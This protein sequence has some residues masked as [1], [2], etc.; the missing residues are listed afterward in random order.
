M[1]IFLLGFLVV[2]LTH[3]SQAGQSD[4]G[5]ND[6]NLGGQEKETNKSQLDML[7]T[8]V[9]QLQEESAHL[10]IQTKEQELK[11][12]EQQL[13]LQDQQLQLQELTKINRARKSTIDDLDEHVKRL[14]HAE[15][16][17]LIAGLS[18]CEV[19]SHYAN[20]G[21]TKGEEYFDVTKKFTFG[22]SF[23]QTPKV[24][25]AIHGFYRKSGDHGYWSRAV[26]ITTTKFEL[27]MY[28]NG[29]YAVGAIWIACA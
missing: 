9:Q 17:P 27:N 14:I 26:S 29:H 28:G 3:F 1:N 12:E 4:N 20:T 22:R 19:G 21:V 2:A 16:D 7:L 5:E 24:V 15:I 6:P 18:H 10:R 13:Q 23:E 25:T 8:Q 11:N